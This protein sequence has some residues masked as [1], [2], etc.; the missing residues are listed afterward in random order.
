M[1]SSHVIVLDS[2]LKRT[3]I[4]VTPGRYMR[5]VL[6]EACKT[7]KLDPEGYNLKTQSNKLVDLSQPFRLSGLAAGAKLQL[8]QGSRSPTVVTVALQLPESE[9]G[10]KLVDKFPSTTSLWLVLRKYEDAVAGTPPRR[11][12]LTQRA[13]PTN[14]GSGAGRLEYEQPCLN[15]M[16]R[17]LEGFSDLQKSLSQLGLTG[18]VMIRL[19]FKSSGQPL[20]EAMRQMEQYFI[21][22]EASS[23]ATEAATSANAPSSTTEAPQSQLNDTISNADLASNAAPIDQQVMDVPKEES[24]TKASSSD[25]SNTLNGIAVFRPPSSN[26]PAAALQEEDSSTFEPGIEHAKAHQAALQRASRNTKLLSDAELA[27]QASAREAKIATIQSV[28][29]RVRYPDQSIIETKVT[30][31]D[32]AADLYA[33]VTETLANPSESYELRFAGPKGPHQVLPHTSSQLLVRDF[34]FRGS[35]LLTLVWAA[36]ASV[37]A[38]QNPSLKEAYRSRAT[39]LKVELQGQRE[40]GQESHRTAMARPENT[41]G[42]SSGKSKIDVEAKMKKFLGFGKK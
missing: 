9:G 11:L 19:S 10:G 33:K 23:S 30:A 41:S 20:E 38:R 18:S 5:E 34:G 17:G 1:A 4:K 36:T 40:A 13:V 8:V 15:V 14:V 6:E 3:Q 29:V 25:T 28:K 16:G 31:A 2:A 32:T 39:D 22:A 7:R 37:Q 27:E 35:I 21:V 24:V 42:G 12:N 26:T